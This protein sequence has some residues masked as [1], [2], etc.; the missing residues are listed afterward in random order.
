MK[1]FDENKII[2]FI[3]LFAILL[4]L[5]LIKALLKRQKHRVNRAL[6]SSGEN[7]TRRRHGVHADELID[8]EIDLAARKLERLNTILDL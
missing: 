8:V 5:F 4:Y 1:R 2:F 3:I 7:Q 6:L